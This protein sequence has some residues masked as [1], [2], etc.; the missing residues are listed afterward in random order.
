MKISYNWLK[1]YLN[2]DLPAEEL[3]AILTEI[4]LEVSK[5][6]QYEAVKGG[7]KGLV[8][9]KVLTCEKHPNADKLSVTT[10]DVGGKVLPIVCGAPNVA[11][12]QKVVVATVGTVLYD[13]DDEFKIKKSKI[14]GEVSEGMICAE[15]E[16][17]LGD[18][19]DGIMVLPENVEAG[20][21]AADYFKI[22]RD[23]VFEIDL[24]PNRPDA[25]SHFGVA[26]DLYAYLKLNTDLDIELKLPDVSDFKVDNNNRKI[27][28]EV[29]NT[30][31]C[32][33]YTG[34]TVSNLTVK[35]SPEWMQNRLKAIG[36]KPINNIVDITNYVLHE[37]G[38]PLHAFDADKVEGDKVVVS[39]VK[40]GTKFTTLDE[41]EINLHENDLMICDANLTP[42][43]I[44]GVMGGLNSGI[45][46]ETKNIF[47]ESAF[48]NPVWVRKTAKRHGISTDSSYRFERG[49]DPN[50]CLWTLKRTALLVKE[51]ADGEI[52]SNIVDI[53]PEKIENFDVE[54]SYAQLEKI[55][56]FDIDKNIVK[57]ILQLLE[58][59]IVSEDDKGLKLKVPTYRFEV[60]RE[61]DVIEE[62]IRIYGYNRIPLSESL[63]TTILVQE[64]CINEKMK[65]TIAHL[66][67]ARGFYEI[68]SFSLLN[69]EI[70]EQIADFD[71]NK[72]IS[73]EN[74]LSKDLEIMRKSLIFGALTAVQRNVNNQ[75]PDVKFYEFGSA[76]F[77]TQ[78]SDFN[79]KYIQ[80][81]RLSLTISGLKNKV[82]WKDGE[83]ASDFYTLKGY[84]E[85]VLKALGFERKLLKI[86]QIATEVYKYGLEYYY[87]N[88]PVM[89]VGAVSRKMLK[90]YDISQDVFFA[91]IEWG[92]LLEKIP[93]QK[94][95]KD[96]VRFNKVKRDLALL[97]DKNISYEQ[98]EK[99]AF[100]TDKKILKEVNIFDVYEGKNIPEGK[101]S[102]AISFVLQDET[103]T[104]TD[105]VIDKLMKKLIYNYENKIGAVVRK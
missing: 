67:T 66:L 25:I 21:P 38:H 2:I 50:N 87:E 39:T 30:E 102:Y 62:I 77:K 31:A 46:D 32:P 57:N 36:L 82:N 83:I 10:V 18:D 58:I 28:V 99:V 52:S 24:T 13:G 69:S 55:I 45:K 90:F 73:L 26:R 78:K 41:Q 1:D 40:P 60:R 70:Y 76:Y 103:K 33:R 56:G 44:G 61:A 48:F 42:L 72:A 37:I 100:D 104:L 65:D 17:G 5:V 23:T 6:E 68:M 92:D 59:Q 34:L 51:L 35:E 43:C 105:K 54:L 101:K 47:I 64:R 27:D 74:P 94:Q 22:Y 12:G 95:F 63:T 96:I 19:H 3:S 80:K 79:E 86:K 49:V 89:I 75:N 98:I 11:A 84:A 16:I 9:G 53:Y 8:I 88:K 81:Y 97:I 14:R 20:T 29:K 4:G 15:D 71:I 85:A 7:L 93:Q 91:E